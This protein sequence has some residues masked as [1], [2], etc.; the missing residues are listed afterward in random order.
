[1]TNINQKEK[2]LKERAKLLQVAVEEV[3]NRGEQIDG[4]EFLLSG[5][6][7][8]IDSNFVSEVIHLKYLTP[9]PCTPAFILGIINIRGKIISIIDIKKFFNLPEK[10]ISNI[11]KVIIVK[12]NDIEVGLLVDEILGN[13]GIYLDTLQK[14]ITSITEV[15]ENFIVGVSKKRVILLDIKEIL[16]NQKI[17]VDEEINKQTGG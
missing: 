15:P 7:Y 13:T 14:K 3:K 8:A 2:I 17:I 16:S 1:M 6:T 12:H 9:L 5:E 10:E 11:N 4:L